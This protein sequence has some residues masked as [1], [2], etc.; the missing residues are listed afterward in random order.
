MFLCAG[1]RKA[2]GRGDCLCLHEC[3]DGDVHLSVVCSNTYQDL[4]GRKEKKTLTLDKS[5]HRVDFYL[6]RC[7]SDFYFSMSPS[8][9]EYECFPLQ[10][11]RRIVSIH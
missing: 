7:P 10:L 11:S 2:G 5:Y 1:Q 9:P 3:L 6:P 4:A 8:A